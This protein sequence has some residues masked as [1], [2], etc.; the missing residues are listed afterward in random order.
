MLTARATT[1]ATVT[2]ETADCTVMA[3][4]AQRV[5]GMTSVGLKAAAL[6]NDGYR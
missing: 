1:S 5:S 3:I 4:L 6:V 2:I